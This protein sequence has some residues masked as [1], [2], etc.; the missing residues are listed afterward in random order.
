[1]GFGLGAAGVLLAA[2]CLFRA[3]TPGADVLWTVCGRL[4]APVSLWILLGAVSLPESR[5]WMRQSLFLYAVHFVIVRF[6]NKGAALAVGRLIPAGLAGIAAVLV[7][8]LLPAFT[9]AVSYGMALALNRW[10]PSV[11]RV[12]SGGRSLGRKN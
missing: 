4:L 2:Y 3:L 12:L 6:V 1:M 10:A 11:W 9:A 5:P 8:L 7:F